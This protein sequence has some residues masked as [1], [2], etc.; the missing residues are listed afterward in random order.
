MPDSAR[1]A[2]HRQRSDC[3]T[4][5]V[6]AGWAAGTGS[7]DIKAHHYPKTRKYGRQ[8][9]LG[10][11]RCC[12]YER[13]PQLPGTIQTM[14]MKRQ[15]PG[16]NPYQGLVKHDCLALMPHRVDH[17]RTFLNSVDSIVHNV[18]VVTE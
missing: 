14:Q 9:V 18:Q 3:C 10:N 2:V 13:F 12:F 1:A 7:A 11:V 16:W 6:S 15:L 5:P 17:C 4:V 8:E